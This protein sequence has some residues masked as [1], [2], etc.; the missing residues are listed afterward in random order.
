V[1]LEP[2]PYVEEAL[3]IRLRPAPWRE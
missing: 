1:L 2:N 3:E